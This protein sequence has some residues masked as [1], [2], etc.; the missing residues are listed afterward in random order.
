MFVSQSAY[1]D[2]MATPARDD[3]RRLRLP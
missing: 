2:N 3:K 1:P